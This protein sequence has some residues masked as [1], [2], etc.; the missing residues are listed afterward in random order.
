MPHID[1]TI[2]KSDPRVELAQ[3]VLLRKPRD[4]LAHFDSGIHSLAANSR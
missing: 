2:L 4:N 3:S 1:I